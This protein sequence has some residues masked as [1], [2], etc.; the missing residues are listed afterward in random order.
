M[1]KLILAAL[2]AGVLSYQATAQKSKK[3]KETAVEA[4]VLT[5]REVWLA[6]LDQLSRP[7]LQSLANDSLK[8]K[9]PVELSV[10]IDNKTS[11]SQVAYL[12]AFGRLLCGIAPWL[13]A[14]GGTPAEVALRD[15]YRQWAVKAVANAVNPQAK[16]YMKFEGAGQPLVDAAFLA[17]AFVRSPWLWEHLDA[18]TKQNVVNSFVKTRE[19]KPGFSNWILFSGM[20][21]AFFCKY[22]YSWDVLRVEY[23]Y[24]QFEQWYLG[25]GIY[26]DG[27]KFHFDYY[28]SYVIQPFLVNIHQVVSAKNPSFNW[29]G[30]RI[31]ERAQRYAHIQEKLVN[32][33]GT[34]PAIGRSLVYRGGAFHHL[35]DMALVHNLPKEISVAQ[36]REALTAILK[37]TTESKTTFDEKGWLKIGFYG[38]QPE[39]ADSYITTGSLYL[40]SFIL[41]PLGLPETDEFWSASPQPWT[42]QRIW[43]GLPVPPDH[44]ID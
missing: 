14:E 22:G 18:T 44:A 25:D 8:I 30:K 32:P 15:T 26:G 11:R 7:V 27:E 33:D 19:I 13:N 38:A 5:T 29:A 34:F 16:D 41:L 42:S 24:R 23:C 9:M 37:K 43:Q 31:M 35:A 3:K 20:I 28:N 40:C 36:T 10:H 2:M 1:K 4:P 12:E 17:L 21:E 39:I 6:H